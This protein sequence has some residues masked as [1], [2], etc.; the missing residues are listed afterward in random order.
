LRGIVAVYSEAELIYIVAMSSG[1]LRS[2]KPL[3]GSKCEYQS[4]RPDDRSKTP[5]SVPALNLNPT[6][7]MLDSQKIQDESGNQE[8]SFFKEML[9]KR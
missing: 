2:A 5:A 4:E 7:R 3:S 8:A 6:E 9:I 1:T